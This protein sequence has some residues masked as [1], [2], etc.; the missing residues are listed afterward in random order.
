LQDKQL[1]RAVSLFCL[2]NGNVNLLLSQFVL[3]GDFTNLKVFP[4]DQ[5]GDGDKEIGMGGVET[6][7]L[8]RGPAYQIFESNG[9]LLRTTFVLNADF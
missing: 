5:K 6:A 4:I 8:M 7:G 9:T 2:F 3:N 1:S